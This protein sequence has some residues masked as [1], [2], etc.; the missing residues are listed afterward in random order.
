MSDNAKA[1]VLASFAADALA[2][3][4][5]WIYNTNVIDKKWGRVDNYIKPERPTY[6]PT[7]N[8][9]DFTHYGDQTLVL[10][11]S[12]AE[13]S[14]FDLNKFAANWQ[15]FFKSYDGY[16]DGATKAT[17]ENF[18]AGDE[19]TQAGSNSDDFAGAARIAPLAYY[20]R[21]DLPQLISSVKAQ[22]A[23]THNSRQVI[24]TAAFLGSVVF[25]VLNNEKPITAV[26]QTQSEGYDR[27]PYAKWIEDGLISAEKDTRQAIL[28]FGQMCEIAAAFPCVIH[29]IVK[30]ENNLQEALIENVMAGGDSAGRGLAVGMVLG[31]HLGVDAIPSEWLSGLKAYRRILAL[32]DQIDQKAG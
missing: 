10:L 12:I 22:T 13:G 17:L 23:L 6:H 2:L 8:M 18:K 14:G 9:G 29:L 31:A 28:D 30:Y 1:M 32:L 26:K 3:G 24:D 11:K 7:K 15:Q 4:V 25:K 5:H 19:P 21:H 20:Y 16:F 27:L